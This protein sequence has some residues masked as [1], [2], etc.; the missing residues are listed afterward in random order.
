MSEREFDPSNQDQ[1]RAR[2][3][4]DDFDFLALASLGFEPVLSLADKQ[5][6]ALVDIQA[7]H[8]DELRAQNNLLQRAAFV[9]SSFNVKNE[10]QIPMPDRPLHA[11][12]FV[13][14]GQLPD[15]RLVQAMGIRFTAYIPTDEGLKPNNY[16]VVVSLDG[17]AYDPFTEE[18]AA[19]VWAQVNELSGQKE[20]LG[21]TDDL[22]AVREV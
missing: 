19:L 5:Q 16:D 7:R 14:P 6:I 1:P 20:Q 3:T 13:R 15:K 11:K 21:L 8:Q 4:Q 12:V 18:D 22:T 17:N 2:F 9:A 10:K